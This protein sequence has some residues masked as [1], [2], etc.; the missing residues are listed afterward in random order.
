MEFTD[1]RAPEPVEGIP[2]WRDGRWLAEAEDWIGAEC[3]RAGL[4]RTGP[5]VGRA[6]MYSVVAPVRPQGMT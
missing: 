6:R 2:S 4:A 5:A 3:A 1:I